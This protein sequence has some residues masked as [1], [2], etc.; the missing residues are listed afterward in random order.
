MNKKTVP[1]AYS[2]C[3][4]AVSANW[5][6]AVKICLIAA[7][8]ILSAPSPAHAYIGPG[9]GFAVAGS[10][11]VMLGPLAEPEAC[12]LIASSPI[13]VTPE[14]AQ[15]ILTRSERWPILLQILCRECLAALE[16]GE[17]GDAWRG[18]G[19]RQMAPFRHLL[20]Q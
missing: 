16:D 19:L 17:V 7:V 2:K 13:P 12:E 4:G 5:N 18:E 10:F 11:F 6:I 8:I 3:G 15:W 1:S 9:A 14:D 20:T